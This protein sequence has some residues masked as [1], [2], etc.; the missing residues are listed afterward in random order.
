MNQNFDNLLSQLKSAGSG[1]KL[2]ALLV[3]LA[4]HYIRYEF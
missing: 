3:G 2:V 1:S 4:I